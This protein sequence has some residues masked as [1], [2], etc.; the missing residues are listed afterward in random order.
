MTGGVRQTRVRPAPSDAEAAPA[1]RS[2]AVE[3]PTDVQ[4]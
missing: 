1:T 3:N 4:G 2:V